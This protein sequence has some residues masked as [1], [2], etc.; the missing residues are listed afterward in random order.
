ML[1]VII[2]TVRNEHIYTKNVTKTRLD[3]LNIEIMRYGR[4]NEGVQYLNKSEPRHRRN[5]FGAMPKTTR[6]NHLRAAI[7]R[8]LHRNDCTIR[9]LIRGRRGVRPEKKKKDYCKNVVHTV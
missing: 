8:R 2:K 1:S 5:F 7:Q 4:P 6:R 3:R 9:T